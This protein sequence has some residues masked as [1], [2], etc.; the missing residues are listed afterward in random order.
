MEKLRGNFANKT[1]TQVV[2]SSN[3]K[4]M[5]PTHTISLNAPVRLLQNYGDST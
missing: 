3:E 4:L 1:V 5:D 2:I